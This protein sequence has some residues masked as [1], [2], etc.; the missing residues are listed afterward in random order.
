VFSFFL[1]FFTIDRGE[2]KEMGE[3]SREKKE[4]NR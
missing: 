2:I 1:T 4:K 3:K